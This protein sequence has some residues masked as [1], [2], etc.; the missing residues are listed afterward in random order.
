MEKKV[1]LNKHN[2]RKFWVNVMEKS[3]PGRRTH[4]VFI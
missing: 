2:F 1:Q 4:V 3:L